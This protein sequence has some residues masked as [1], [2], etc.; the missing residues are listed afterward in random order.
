MS[1]QGRLVET[2]P[3]MSYVHHQT[4][5]CLAL[6]AA[7]CMYISPL[8]LPY[9]FA[10]S[11]EVL[12]ELHHDD[13][14]GPSC[15]HAGGPEQRVEDDAVVVEP[16]QEDDLL[17]LAGVVETGDL[18]VHLQALRDVHNDDMHGHAVLL[19]PGHVETLQGQE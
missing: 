18:L 19:A 12:R 8:D 13:D 11:G 17:L 7:A 10:Q 3:F 16:R 2:I 9:L 15:Q 5:I 14:E 4:N 6:T 1:Q